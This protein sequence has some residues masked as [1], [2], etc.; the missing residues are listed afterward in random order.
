MSPIV[1][2]HRQAR[3]RESRVKKAERRPRPAFCLSPEAFVTNRAPA[4][5]P[6]QRLPTPPSSNRPSLTPPGKARKILSVRGAAPARVS[7]LEVHQ[8]V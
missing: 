4:R 2:A 1:P 7:F 5:R 3:K 8:S 6:N